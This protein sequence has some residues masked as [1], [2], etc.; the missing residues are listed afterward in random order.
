MSAFKSN[1][2]AGVSDVSWVLLKTQHTK[3]S[4][5]SSQTDGRQTTWGDVSMLQCQQGSV[6]LTH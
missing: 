1:S 2:W 5:F 4:R 3:R 6:V